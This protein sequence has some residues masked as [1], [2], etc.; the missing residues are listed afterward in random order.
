[1]ASGP[2]DLTEALEV[3]RE[4]GAGAVLRGSVVEA[5]P[6]VRITAELFTVAGHLLARVRAD[7]PADS[8]LA[9]VDNLSVRLLRDVWR[10][11]EP[12]PEMRVSS[13]T[14]ASLDAIRDYLRGEQF[15]RRSQWDSAA[16]YFERAVADDSTF[17]LAYFRLAHTFGWMEGHGSAR[18]VAYLESGKRESTRLPERER[19]LMEA[20]DLFEQG[21]VESVRR[22]YA[23]VSE[24][25]SDAYGWFELADAQYHAQQVLGLTDGE[26]YSSFDSAINLVPTLIPALIHPTEMSLASGDRTRFERYV[27]LVEAAG[28][29]D[30]ANRFRDIAL[31]IW[32]STDSGAAAMYR[33]A[34]RQTT[35]IDL[36]IRAHFALARDDPSRIIDALDRALRDGVPDSTLTGML[37]LKTRFLSSLGR[38]REAREVLDTLIITDPAQAVL[39]AIYPVI[40]GFADPTFA[41]PGVRVLNQIV[42]NN[43]V[44][45][46]CKALFAA[47]MS[48]PAAAR[49][50][51]D[52]YLLRM[53]V[54]SSEV[55]GLLTG[56]LGWATLLEGDSVAGVEQIEESLALVG[57]APGLSSFLGPLT[58]ELGVI[59]SANPETRTEGVRRLQYGIG[60]EYEY[61]ALR[62]LALAHALEEANDVQG[63]VAE[64]TRFIRLWSGA[65]P[66]LQSAVAAAEDAV[67]RLSGERSTRVPPSG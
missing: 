26:I 35:R 11:Q 57:F 61:Q 6:E 15:Y 54:D 63:A 66:Q 45:V 27:A 58:F 46:F 30:E 18:A 44:V 53:Q 52:E 40:A 24:H 16:V 3:G 55:D 59:K 23:Y 49:A 42:S 38:L 12:M 9:L 25:P 31:A 14:T 28:G 41:E 39:P 20:H 22:L 47:A 2:V 56:I 5:G 62:S 10:S 7:G 29:G 8:V 43:S 50:V 33:V 36:V 19:A 34:R 60:E 4:V 1:A 51:V 17:A 67:A 64:Y 48:D 21:N 13:I 32:D 37:I 65:D